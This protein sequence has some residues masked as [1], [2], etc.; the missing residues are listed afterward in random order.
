MLLW[1]VQKKKKPLPF[2]IPLLYPW[3]NSMRALNNCRSIFWKVKFMF[4]CETMFELFWKAIQKQNSIYGI[5]H[6]QPIQ[7]YRM[8]KIY[9]FRTFRDVLSFF[10]LCTVSIIMC[11]WGCVYVCINNNAWVLIIKY[12][13]W[14]NSRLLL[15][16]G[17][18]G[19]RKKGKLV[20]AFPPWILA[21]I[22]STTV[23][24]IFNNI[25]MCIVTNDV[26]VW[27]TI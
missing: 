25:S 14:P 22:M 4:A 26:C 21:I 24:N 9:T 15:K 3:N 12:T 13:S 27:H 8:F 7:F 16:I 1:S 11:F 2:F 6:P 5:P 20:T 18:N 17:Y 19:S 10:F 23:Y